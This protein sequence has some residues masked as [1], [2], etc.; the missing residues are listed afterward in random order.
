MAS[1]PI[2]NLRMR[3]DNVSEREQR[4]LL[5]LGITFIVVIVAWVGMRINNRLEDLEAKNA[6]LRKAL[7]ALDLY[8]ATGG[9]DT[10]PDVPIPETP[11]KL[12]T[13][14]AKIADEVG[15]KIPT[16]NQLQPVP[17]D[18]FT[19][20]SI[21]IEVRD[22]TIQQLTEFLQK[23]EGDS[24]VVVVK[25]LNVRQN[26]RDRAKLDVRMDVATYSKTGGEKAEE[27]DKDKE[28]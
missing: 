12:Q 21:R 14:L 5:A 17:H 4:L 11:L 10:G 23:V 19:E 8:R 27:S 7:A 26:F 9:E 18:E 2:D 20:N 3:W 22:L 15:I 6:K 25:T 16:F 13:Y 24:Q 28:G 1:S